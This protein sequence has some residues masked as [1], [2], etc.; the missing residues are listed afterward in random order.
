MPWLGRWLS[1]DPIGIEGGI[2][3]F[4]YCKGNPISKKDKNGL[5]PLD[6]YLEQLQSSVSNETDFLNTASRIEDTFPGD[7]TNRRRGYTSFQG[8]QRILRRLREL[9]SLA[10]FRHIVQS[11]NSVSDEYGGAEHLDRN[12]ALAIAFR[13]S[14]KKVLSRSSTRVDSF[15]RGGLDR[16]YGERRRLRRGGF[17]PREVERRLLPG[18][19][20]ETEGSTSLTTRRATAAS[21]RVSDLLTAYGAVVSERDS[22]FFRTAERREL[23]T[24]RLSTRVRRLWNALFFGGPGGLNYETYVREERRHGHEEGWIASHFGAQTIMDY[25][26]TH[27]YTADDILRLDEIAPDLYNMTRTKAAFIVTAEAEVLDQFLPSHDPE[28]GPDNDI[29]SVGQ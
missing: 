23:N 1:A 3:L 29:I 7:L 25:L 18:S 5:I 2:N 14:G 6:E 26:V 22:R 24:D 16:L 8:G 13:E 11:F 20:G 12:L 17:L 21:I 9:D 15:G 19:I 4:E 28:R 10:E 27:G